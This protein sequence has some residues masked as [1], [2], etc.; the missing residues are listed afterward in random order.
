MEFM[1]DTANLQELEQGIAYYPVDGITTNPSILKAELPMDYFTHLKAIKAL[2]NG[3]TMH[4]Q[5][6]QMTCEGMLKEAE[7]IWE[8][9]GKDVY[10]KIPVTEEG[11]KAIKEIKRLGG[12]VTATSIY[13]PIQGLR[14]ASGRPPD[15]REYP[16]R[17]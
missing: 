12:L 11:V 3:R 1:L 6:G 2:C 8:Q 14:R 17:F 4:V 9:L 7:T 10:L 5:L 13:Y 15:R 16:H